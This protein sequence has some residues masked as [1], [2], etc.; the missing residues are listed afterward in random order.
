MANE[1]RQELRKFIGSGSG[2]QIS[3]SIYVVDGRIVYETENEGHAFM[4]DGD[5]ISTK[6][7]SLDDLKNNRVRGGG[8]Y[9][10]AGKAEVERQLQLMK[11]NDSDS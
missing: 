2:S 9:Y 8:N 10:E 5:A 7:I 1:H 6:W 3:Y 4:R 11:E